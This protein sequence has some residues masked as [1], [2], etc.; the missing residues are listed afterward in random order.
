MIDGQ[1]YVF[2]YLPF[3]L[4][5]APWAFNRVVRPLKCYLHKLRYLVSSFLDDFLLLAESPGKLRL[6]VAEVLQLFKR[7]GFQINEKKSSTTPSQRVEY[8]GVLFLLDSLQLTLPEKKVQKIVNLMG[9]MIQRSQASRRELEELL[10]LLSF[11]SSLVPLG[12]LRLRPLLMWMNS[13]TAP[14][15]RDTPVTLERSFKQDLKVW[16]NLEFLRTP[17][18]MSL[19][20][21][22]LQL[23][24][25][26]SRQG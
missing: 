6:V 23:M 11:A 4:A 19:P 15:S 16:Q 25:D 9:Q 7:L 17:V 20:L 12:R 2:Q 8:L 26:A 3:G 18:P 14:E 1:I 24:T 13:H 22:T 5:V 10:G 21:P